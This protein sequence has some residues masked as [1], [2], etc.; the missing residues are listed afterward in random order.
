MRFVSV[1]AVVCM[2]GITLTVGASGCRRDRDAYRPPQG[3]AAQGLAYGLGNPDADEREDA[4]KDLRDDGGPP[5]DSVP[6]LLT[7]IRQEQNKKAF[8]QM[9][10]TLGASGSPEAKPIID[11]HLTH[12]DEDLREAA[13]DAAKRWY[14]RTGQQAPQAM[15]K[16]V[17]LLQSPDWEK[18][19]GAADDLRDNNGP[20]PPAVPYLIAAAQK[21]THPKALG[22]MLI[23]LGSSGA[24]E[25]K[26]LIEARVNDP[27]SD[28]RRWARRGMKNWLQKNGTMVRQDV[29]TLPLPAVSASASVSTSSPAP[30][31]P[32]PGES[33][34]QQFGTACAA[35]P[36][37][38]GKCKKD[39]APLSYT[40]VQAWADCVNSSTDPC[41]KA[42]TAC[43]AK[44]GK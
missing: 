10:I 13:E 9:M 14:K 34:C 35:D 22:A 20:P 18:R 12:Q 27:D 36:F 16:E 19:R 26:P 8:A 3:A 11:A 40:A 1:F 5:M 15:P 42:H 21:E 37:D 6:H 2:T 4:A 29:T 30:A 31:A 44:A 23:T 33:G 7:A 17:A 41:Q 32:H 39:L 28:M 25:A 24:P 38:T 43:V